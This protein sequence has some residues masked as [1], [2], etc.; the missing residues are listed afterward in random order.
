MINTLLNP[1]II[2]WDLSPV[3]T[4]DALNG[5][6]CDELLKARIFV[7]NLRDTSGKI[8]GASMDILARLQGKQLKINLT[9]MAG[10]LEDGALEDLLQRDNVRI[11]IEFNSMEE[12][13][14]SADM[15]T[16]LKEAGLNAGLSFYLSRDNWKDLPA[17]TSFCGQNHI[18]ELKLP[19]RRAGD[20]TFYFSQEET[21]RVSGELE[22]IDMSNVKMT[23]H[24]PFLWE[25]FHGKANPNE[26]GCNAARTMMYIDGNYD[27]SPCPIMP[28]II[29]SLRDSSLHELF[30]SKQ[31]KKVR[32]DLS[33][34]P[35]DCTICSKSLLCKG[36]CRGRTFIVHQTLN[37][38]DPAC[39]FNLTGTN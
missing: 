20:G 18:K 37:Y 6:I 33:V 17:V 32:K 28:V 15:M 19:I 26:E 8:S 31:R 12:L 21:M 23:I 25:L 24:D 16:K 35:L 36:G 3:E 11:Y 7:L 5:R 27:L 2:Y 13:S 9:V 29:G 14:A 34:T 30:V 22:A 10:C 38:Q 39:P 4:D 1:I